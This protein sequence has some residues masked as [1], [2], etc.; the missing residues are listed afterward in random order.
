LRTV[1]DGYEF[2]LVEGVELPFDD[3]A[4]DVVPAPEAALTL[5]RRALPTMVMLLT[6]RSSGR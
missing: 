3:D 4:F 5:A 2:C 1:A 6:R